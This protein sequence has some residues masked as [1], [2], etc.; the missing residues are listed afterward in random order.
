MQFAHR[1]CIQKCCNKIGDI[2]CEICNQFYSLDYTIPPARTNPDVM[3]IDIR[4]AWGPQIDLR[5]AHF[6]DF[7]SENHFLELD[8]EDYG[9]GSH[10]NNAYLRFMALI[11]SEKQVSCHK[12]YKRSYKRIIFC[13]N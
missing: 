2:T 11:V 9:V 12:F 3:T 10:N 1:K 13:L 4:H 6:L 7:D 5:D 8:Y